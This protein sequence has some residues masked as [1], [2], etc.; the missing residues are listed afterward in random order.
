VKLEISRSACRYWSRRLN[1]SVDP[2]VAAFDI[3]VFASPP[4]LIL[5]VVE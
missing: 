5:P 2:K 4:G 3:A 1:G